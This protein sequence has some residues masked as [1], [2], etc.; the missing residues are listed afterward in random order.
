MAK[1]LVSKTAG[2]ASF[3]IRK[4][5]P[6]KLIPFKGEFPLLDPAFEKEYWEIIDSHEFV[7]DCPEWFQNVIFKG[8]RIARMDKAFKEYLNNAGIYD[9]FLKMKSSEKSTW[10][11]RFLNANSMDIEALQIN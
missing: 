6:S 3:Y 2:E 9:E 7:E 5:K 4:D 10:L 11:V 8:Q 1:I